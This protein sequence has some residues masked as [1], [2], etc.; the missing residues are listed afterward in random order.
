LGWNEPAGQE[1]RFKILSGI[2]P[3]NEHTFLDA[4]CGHGDLITF[5]RKLSPQIHYYGVEQIPA[6]LQVAFERNGHLPNTCFFEGDF[7][8]AELPLVDYTI[9]C[10]SLNY[11]NSD[12]LFILKT[13]EKLYNNSRIGFGFNLLSKIE[14]ANAFLQAYKPDYIKAFCCK[15]ATHVTL[16]ENYY[17]D[18]YTVYMY[19]YTSWG[20]QPTSCQSGAPAKLI[21]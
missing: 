4:G 20:F 13:I 17:A 21:K 12:D 15:L 3:L 18:D 16:I 8:A 19:H 2:G 7:S 14:P 6:I 10:G 11:H 1:L 9:A 5:L